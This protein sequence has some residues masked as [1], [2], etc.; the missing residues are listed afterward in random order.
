MTLLLQTRFGAQYVQSADST[1]I[2]AAVVIIGSIFLLLIIG[3]FI[4]SRRERRPSAQPH[5]KFRKVTF[6]RRASKAGLSRAQTHTLESII[7]M[8]SV[9]R[10]CLL[11]TNSR[12]LDISLEKAFS[13][14]DASRASDSVK[15]NQRLALYGIKQSIERRSLQSGSYATTRQLAPN[16]PI[17]LSLR[18]GPLFQSRIISILKDGLAI[19][20]PTDSAGNQ[21]RWAKWSSLVV[22]FWKDNGEGY[23][24]A[25]KVTGYNTVKGKNC[26]F[27]QH[28]NQIKK[29]RQRK[30]KRKDILR[31]CY[32]Y[33][34]KIIASGSG[35]NQ[36]RR[37]FVDTKKGT[38]AKI[39]EV[40]VGGCSIRSPQVV[41][42]SSLVRVDFETERKSAVSTYGKVMNVRKDGVYG[43]MM[44]IMFTKVS[45]E[46]INRIN[47][48]IYDYG[49]SS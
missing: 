31:P 5:Q 38:L 40:S 1:T 49:K 29:A 17:S 32:Y 43:Y 6:R 18:T 28:S 24:F 4:T 7:R 23:S 48:Y 19:E 16:Q 37:A 20:I 33:P 10:P 46:N 2:I 12:Q 44:H 34:V 13:A 26:A 21:L 14:I 25:S 42:K 11:L 3:G 47:F 45:K 9:R 36:T 15:E 27:I 41:G 39:V 22:N 30:F 8:G 35:R